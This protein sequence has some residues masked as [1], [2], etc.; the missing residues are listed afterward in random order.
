MPPKGIVLPL[1]DRPAKPTAVRESRLPNG[2]LS[3]PEK[4]AFSFEPLSVSSFFLKTHGLNPHTMKLKAKSLFNKHLAPVPGPR[5]RPCDSCFH[6]R[7][8]TQAVLRCLCISPGFVQPEERR[9]GPR[10][11]SMNGCLQRAGAR[12]KTLDFSKG[13]MLGKDNAL[14]VVFYPA[15][16]PGADKRG[17]LWSGQVLARGEDTGGADSLPTLRDCSLKGADVGTAQLFQSIFARLVGQTLGGAE[18]VPVAKGLR[19]GDADLRN[20]H[21][22][23][24]QLKVWKWKYILTVIPSQNCSTNEEKRDIGANFLSKS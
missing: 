15:R 22:A 11:R 23:P 16:D 13:R 1:N 24:H 7:N 17:L 6:V 2:G 4:T 10:Q 14:E 18:R 3:I 9:T 21:H 19:G 8:L 5:Q 20:G 12:K